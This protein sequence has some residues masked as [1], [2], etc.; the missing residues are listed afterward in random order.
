MRP[1]SLGLF[2]RFATA[3]RRVVQRVRV[4][5]LLAIA[6]LLAPPHAQAGQSTL[7]LQAA[8][9]L[10]SAVPQPPADSEPW[11]SQALPDNWN[12]SRP[13]VGGLGWYRIRFE[14]PQTPSE[15]YAVYL[16]KLSMNAAVYVNGE[17]VGDG[18]SFGEP[19]ARHWNRPLLFP[20]APGL[21]KPGTNTLDV[22]L[23]AYANTRGGLD[24]VQIGP[25]AVLYPRYEQRYFVQAILPQL[26]NIVVAALGLFALAMGVQR[27]GEI[28]YLLFCVFSVLWA[29]RST[30]MFI[31]DIPVAAFY[32]DIWVQ[33]SHGW[34]ALL[35]V[36][37]AMRYSGLRWQRLE[38]ALIGYGLL[39][40]VVMYLAGPAHI[41][42]A[43]SNWSFVMVPVA[44]F[45]EGFLI[46]VAWRTHSAVNALLAVVWGLIIAA[47][48]HD[49]LVHRNQLAFDSFYWTSYV[50][51]LLSFVMGWLLVR[52]FVTALDTAE[53]MN[54][55]LEQRVAQKHAELEQH[56]QRLQEM[57]RQSALAEE[58]RRLMSDMHDGVGS[59]LI[60]T[61]DAVERGRTQPDEIARDLRDI[62][63][64]L[65]LTIDSLQP[66][67]NDLLTVLG[68]L[69]YR[70]EGRFKRQGILLHWHVSDVPQ[71]TSLTPQNV[72]HILRILQE[73]FT[74]II[75]HAQ[76]KTIEVTTGVVG[77]EV[78]LS[79]VDDGQGFSGEREGRGLESM[80]RRAQQLGARLEIDST[81]RGTR[82]SLRMAAAARAQLAA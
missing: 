11:Q 18:G 6:L 73:A 50:M 56:F 34:C 82:V 80:R 22:R 69:R 57:E 64:S 66:S 40:P 32:W 37:L 63:D 52:R 5:V 47:S 10:L 68:N 36:V 59:Q 16:R 13:G 4:V 25:K 42:T 79:V 45:F 55:E 28:T 71:M 24:E 65:R 53:H 51:V 21:L 78:S 39:G 19:V 72:M 1:A 12:L 20:V 2:V 41:H 44:V 35:Y 30:H 29:C 9:F 77:E 75:K 27:R 26:C 76:A 38:S 58:R 70:L 61:L 31:R 8:Q 81:A 3:R 54:R 60:A 46:R 33:S 43:A 49:G 14:L 17:H 62:L 7:T 48:V 23:W 67:E 15:L 74:N